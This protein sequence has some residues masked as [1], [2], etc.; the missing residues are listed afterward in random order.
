MWS[1]QKITVLTKYS[2][3]TILKRIFGGTECP[4]PLSI[5]KNYLMIQVYHQIAVLCI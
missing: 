3:F 5:Y 1:T 4:G 2:D